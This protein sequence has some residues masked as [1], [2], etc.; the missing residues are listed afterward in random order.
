MYVQLEFGAINFVIESR[1]LKYVYVIFHFL[2]KNC[3]LLCQLGNFPENCCD[4]KLSPR[5]F[6]DTS[7]AV[8]K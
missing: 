3:E 8:W 6:S 2:H 4:L 7:R 1:D 5:S